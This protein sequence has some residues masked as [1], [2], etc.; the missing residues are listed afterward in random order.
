M[1]LRQ[2][3]GRHFSRGAA[4][5]PSIY[6][7]NKQAQ[8]LVMNKASTFSKRAAALLAAIVLAVWSGCGRD[9][10]EEAPAVR[11]V[12]ATVVGDMTV[13]ER[14]SF[15]G[16]ATA[17]KEVDLAFR[18]AGPLQSI[19][20]VGEEVKEGQVVAQIQPR[21]FDV[22][23]INVQAQLKDAQAELRNAER[24][25][26]RSEEL[27]RQSPPAISQQELDARITARDRGEA[28][29]AALIASLE[30]ARNQRVDTDLE[31][32][33]D[34]VVTATYVE[35][36]ENVRAKQPILRI[37]DKSEIE[38][39]VNIPESLM[40]LSSKIKE[41][42]IEFDAF[43]G[44]QFEAKITEIGNEA[45]ATTRT[46][47]VTVRMDQPE[48]EDVTIFPGMSGRAFSKKPQLAEGEEPSIVVPV[49][50]V[51]APTAGDKSYVWLI[52]AD[53]VER[54]EVT[55]G[56]LISGGYV[57]DSGLKKGDMIATAGV[58]FLE[59]GQKIRPQLDWEEEGQ[60]E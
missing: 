50:A 19:V 11:P 34:G 14:R 32:P 10:P 8:G 5:G 45:S 39:V 18:V 30:D 12:R 53:T 21:D 4:I 37:L 60:A 27:I 3:P 31:A 2:V 35:N 42:I 56:Q 38:M 7:P 15:P 47:P 49:T 51:F 20:D 25:L 29:V 33:F 22:A 9:K 16:R 1:T 55:I 6:F 52:K 24:N 17:V 28:N 23:V 26:Q 57:V 48:D 41:A 59:E 54:R 40:Y 36:F 44:R 58:H 43:P 46:F 13:L